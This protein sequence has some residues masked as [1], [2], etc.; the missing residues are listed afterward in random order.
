MIAKD[1][2]N[3][4]LFEGVDPARGNFRMHITSSHFD[5]PLAIQLVSDPAKTRQCVSIHGFKSEIKQICLGGLN[6]ALKAEFVAQA[7]SADLKY[8]VVECSALR[9]NEPANIVNRCAGSGIQLELSSALRR[10]LL[11]DSGEMNRLAETIRHSLTAPLTCVE[12]DE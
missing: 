9:G 5:E 7:K 1:D 12:S 8:E 6:R 4:Y 10:D 11:G 2:F 3:L